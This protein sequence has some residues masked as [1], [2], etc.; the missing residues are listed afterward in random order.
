V[1]PVIA[2]SALVLSGL[3]PVAVA[4]QAVGK[5]MDVYLFLAGMMVVSELARRRASLTGL[6]A[7][8]YELHADRKAASFS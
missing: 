3:V 4:A 1:W 6:P 7:T 5:G 8:Q 2:A